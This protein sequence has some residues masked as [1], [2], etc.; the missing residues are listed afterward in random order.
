MIEP[1]LIS[2]FDIAERNHGLVKTLERCPHCNTVNQNFLGFC[3][4]GGVEKVASVVMGCLKCGALFLS[5][6]FLKK[7][8]IKEL[9]DNAGVGP[10]PNTQ[11]DE[12]AA[13]A[14]VV[15]EDTVYKCSKC[16]KE[17]KNKRGLQI[18]E[19]ACNGQA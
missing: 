9:Q 1:R 2:R 17:A 19:G 3:D 16:G 13:S 7:L 6:E 4:P 5:R 10:E 15:N 11:E 14:P 12:S 8:D 18:H